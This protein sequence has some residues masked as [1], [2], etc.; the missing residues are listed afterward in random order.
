DWDGDLVRASRSTGAWAWVE[1]D[2]ASFVSTAAADGEDRFKKLLAGFES[3]DQV[4][5]HAYGIYD[6]AP[7]NPVMGDVDGDGDADGGMVIGGGWWIALSD[8]GRFVGV[9]DHR[10]RRADKYTNVYRNWLTGAGGGRTQHFLFDMNGDRAADAITYAPDNLRVT[11]YPS[12]G[13]DFSGTS[14]SFTLGSAAARLLVG[15]VDN[16]QRGDLILYTAGTWEVVRST[17][18][19]F[20]DLGV[21]ATNTGTDSDTQLIADVDNDGFMDAVSFYRSTGVWEVARSTGTSFDSAV[22][23]ATGLGTESSVQLLGNV[24]GDGNFD[25]ETAPYRSYADAVVIHA[26]EDAEVAISTGNSYQNAGTWLSYGAS[27]YYVPDYLASAAT[28]STSTYQAEG[29]VC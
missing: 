7:P 5:D 1:S 25:P 9:D 13:A 8:R 27:R 2:R 11:V 26:G 24:D 20:V 28:C 10:Y 23:W 19:G 6:Q 14:F 18:T 29:S 15:D 22:Q 3:A 4:G 17:G 21:W 16:D 12:S